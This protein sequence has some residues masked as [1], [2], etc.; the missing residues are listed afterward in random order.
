MIANHNQVEEEPTFD[1]FI[2]IGMLDIDISSYFMNCYSIQDYSTKTQVLSGLSPS[3]FQIQDDKQKTNQKNDEIF[4]E[5][6]QTIQEYNNKDSTISEQS[7]LESIGQINPENNLISQFEKYQLDDSQN[8]RLSGSNFHA[9]ILSI[10]N[11]SNNHERLKQGFKTQK[12]QDQSLR[13]LKNKDQLL[14]LENEYQKCKNWDKY[15]MKKLSMQ[16]GLTRNQIYKWKWDRQAQEKN[17]FD[18]YI[19]NIKKSSQQVFKVLKDE[20]LGPCYKDCT[21]IFEISR[22][23][24]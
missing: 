20:K 14:M 21:V 13:L 11:K 22:V 18:R 4:Q 3:K 10:P 8:M 9:S 5:Q 16:L 19:H 17:Q 2:Q 23:K 12:S 1:D 15:H 7:Y 24:Q 6:I